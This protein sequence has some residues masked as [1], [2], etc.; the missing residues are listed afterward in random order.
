MRSFQLKLYTCTCDVV[1]LEQDV[2]FRKQVL[3][4]LVADHHN[5]G[6]VLLHIAFL[7]ATTNGLH[8]HF[9]NSCLRLRSR[10][11]INLKL[12]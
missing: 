6:E 7:E 8:A 2:I 1:E 5:G 10:F 11:N 12:L 9:F 3:R 4:D